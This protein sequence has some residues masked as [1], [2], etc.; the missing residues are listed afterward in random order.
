[1]RESRLLG[2][3]RA[4]A[5]WL[6]YSTLLMRLSFVVSG[7]LCDR[8]RAA[9]APRPSGSLAVPKLYSHRSPPNGNFRSK[10]GRSWAA[11]DQSEQALG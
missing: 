7:D 11:A 5:K 6:S 4:K 10:A 8:H 2:S 1:M 3:V 9:W